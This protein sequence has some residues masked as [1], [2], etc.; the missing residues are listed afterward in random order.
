VARADG[1]L[2]ADDLSEQPDLVISTEPEAP[3]LQVLLAIWREWPREGRL[4]RRNVFDPV[5]FP[6]LLPWIVLVESDA[7]PNR[8]R[9]YDL[10][11]RYI[12]SG[13]A[14]TLQSQGLTGTHVSA[15]PD[16]FPERWFPGFDRLRETAAPIV[17]RGKPY[18]ID[19]A[20]LRFEILCLPLARNA[21]ADA[22]TLG[23]TLACLHHEPY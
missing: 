10:L 13:V 8:Y 6:R 11:M 9:D 18:L 20:H 14:E 3:D 19:R 21:P 5:E 15:L 4:P 2:S 23:F 22:D 12:G 17:L 16:P 1:E 7:H